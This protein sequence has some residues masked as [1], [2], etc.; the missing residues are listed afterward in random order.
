MRLKKADSLFLS[1]S[2]LKLLSA[3]CFY[4]SNSYQNHGYRRISQTD[5]YGNVAAPYKEKLFICILSLARK[6]SFS[7]T[8]IQI[9]FS[10]LF[11][12]LFFFL[13]YTRQALPDLLSDE[14]AAPFPPF[15]I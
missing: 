7:T 3:L 4:V 8:E 6:Q 12:D 10:H 15:A 9:P 5:E 11:H 14:I 2:G 13:Y 1:L